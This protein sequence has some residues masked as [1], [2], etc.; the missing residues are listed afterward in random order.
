M[1]H[2]FCPPAIH[3][4]FFLLFFPS[5]PV[6]LCHSPPAVDR[7]MP[8][9]DLSIPLLPDAE[10]D[11]PLPHPHHPQY[12]WPEAGPSSP[13]STPSASTVSVSSAG[14]LGNVDAE[15]AYTT[16]Y[17]SE[18]GDGRER[19]R[20]RERQASGQEQR[21]R[22]DGERGTVMDMDM[23]MEMEMETER[24]TDLSKVGIF[25]AKA[26]AAMTGA[27]ATSLLSTSRI[28]F[29]CSFGWS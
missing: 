23:G 16:R 12:T 21:R 10:H 3:H 25:G 22:A 14:F 18:I 6:T 27:M 20:G 8:H 26:I 15:Y 5:F 2:E 24:D 19:G 4:L 28:S 11:L 1:A 13:R 17:P 9:P 7:T 29:F